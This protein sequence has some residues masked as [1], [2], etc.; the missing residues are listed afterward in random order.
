MRDHIIYLHV[1]AQR[2]RDSIWG[3]KDT[4]KGTKEKNSNTES[5]GGSNGGQVNQRR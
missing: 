2:R 3:T 1:W 4:A 5:G